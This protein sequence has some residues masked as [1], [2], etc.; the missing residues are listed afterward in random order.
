MI[1]YNYA[2]DL[3]DE[4]KPR[5]LLLT[6]GTVTV[7]GTNYTVTGATITI[8]NA[9]LE[10]EKFEL[11]QSLCSSDQI[12]FGSCE[13][14]YV[15]F[16]MH[17]NVPTVKGKTLK[18]YIIP[19]GDASKMLQLGIF[20]VDTDELSSDRT[21]RVVTAYD[22]MYDILNADVA[23]WYNT[24]L[25]TSSSSKTLAQFRE[26]FLDHFNLTAEAITLPNDTI[27]IKRTI[28]PESLSGA[29]V[30]KAICEINGCFGTITNEGEFRFVVLSADIDAG[31]FPSD[32]LYPADDLYP[33]DV[34][35][36]TDNINKA[37]YIS[38]DFED[39]NSESITQ[40][41]IRADDSDV[42]A[43][44]GTAG[45]HYIIT[46]NFLVFGY[47]AADLTS[48]ATNALTN[49]TG[50]YYRP[51]RVNAIGNPLHE[52]GDPIRIET[53]YRGIVTYILERKYTGIH[54]MR[55]VYTAKGQK[56]CSGELNSVA[57][58]FKQLVNKT[59]SLKVDVDGV[60]AYVE[61]QLDDTIQ[62]SYAYMT[63]QEIGLKVSKSNIVGDLNDNI[64]SGIT[65]GVNS[66]A[67]E[68]S[69][70]FTVDAT[71]FT[72]SSNGTVSMNGA[73]ISEGSLTISNQLAIGYEEVSIANGVLTASTTVTGATATLRGDSLNVSDNFSR[74]T[75]VGVNGVSTSENI[76]ASGYVSAASATFA[77]A[78]ATGSIEA[79][80]SELNIYGASTSTRITLDDTGSNYGIVLSS[81]VN[82]GNGSSNTIRIKGRDVQWKQYSSLAS[83]DYVLVE[84]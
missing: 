29:D 28:N 63:E 44:V 18:A 10:A 76:L 32:T 25:P 59:A 78:V 54:A 60:Q 66:I 37:H 9:E 69:G 57:S 16:T 27:T 40:L 61:E 82:I 43:T 84:A 49:M 23:A 72:L 46:G 81:S 51:C 45:N 39:Y 33:G 70:T 13:S 79:S 77:G 26:D 75:T 5:N 24:E 64:G 19:G 17:E 73:T 48:A 71:N 22:A 41:T 1:S 4:N 30:I 56:K 42:G 58:Q 67:I 8:T 80:G 6:D 55:D 11:V 36:D 50:R 62:G 74:S 3:L 35:H 2:D 14:G 83:S 52:A 38:A 31:L 47:G 53:T 15:K 7:S 21:K 34:N 65:I 68:S 12:R 20:K